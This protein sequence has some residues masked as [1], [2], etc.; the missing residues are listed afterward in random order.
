LLPAAEVKW[1]WNAERGQIAALIRDFPRV[2]SE[3]VFAAAPNGTHAVADALKREV[4]ALL[5]RLA[6]PNRLP[7]PPS[8]DGGDRKA[9]AA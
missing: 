9:A 6:D 2:A 3:R 5:E 7:Q 4:Y 8:N 1:I